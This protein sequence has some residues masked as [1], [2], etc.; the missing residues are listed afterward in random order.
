M[1]LDMV[2][3]GVVSTL[4]DTKPR[5]GALISRL[6]YEVETQ[7]MFV[8]KNVNTGQHRRYQQ[9]FAQK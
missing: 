4:L 2:S 9:W 8:L 1:W 3:N 5:R 7:L 6:P